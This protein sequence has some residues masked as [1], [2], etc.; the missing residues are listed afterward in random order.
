DTPSGPTR[1]SL[2]VP[3][4]PGAPRTSEPSGSARRACTI[5][6]SR[7]PGPMTRVFTSL[8]V[9]GLAVFLAG[10]SEFAQWIPV[11]STT[12]L[13][14]DITYPM[15]RAQVCHAGYGCSTCG[16]WSHWGPL[17]SPGSDFE[18]LWVPPA[19]ILFQR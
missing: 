19:G 3:A 9:V 13:F 1:T 14:N 16:S 15:V 7:P 8:S 6:C 2:A 4:V 18:P 10:M 12:W 5:A 11:D 17:L